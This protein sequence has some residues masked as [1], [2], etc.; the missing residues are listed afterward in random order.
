MTEALTWTT[1][2]GWPWHD[3]WGRHETLYFCSI[4]ILLNL[5]KKNSNNSRWESV[6]AQWVDPTA[7]LG[8]QK[9]VQ[10]IMHLVQKVGKHTIMLK[11]YYL[12]NISGI[13]PINGSF[14]QGSQCTGF[15]H[16]TRY[17]PAKQL[18]KIL[19]PILMLNLCWNDECQATSILQYPAR[20]W[21]IFTTLLVNIAS[22][23]HSTLLVFFILM[24]IYCC[25]VDDVSYS[26]YKNP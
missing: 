6:E 7:D 17:G 3:W 11:S 20:L 5:H 12:A 8:V 9:V 26:M 21:R 13:F 4:Q 14:V 10:L 16:N 24:V 22:S 18:T 1:G 25:I 2:L 19:A 23:A 15:Q